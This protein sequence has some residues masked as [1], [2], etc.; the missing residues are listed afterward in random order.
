M[1]FRD[2]PLFT[3][4]VK[5]SVFAQFRIARRVWSEEGVNGLPAI[6]FKKVSRIF[7]N[8]APTIARRSLPITTSFVECDKR[9]PAKVW[10]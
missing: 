4:T 5:E 3:V 8:L 10:D 6:T 7:Y 9:Q 1:I 2:H